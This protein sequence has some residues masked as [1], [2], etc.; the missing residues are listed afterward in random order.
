MEGRIKIHRKIEAWE[1]YTDANVFRV[2]FHL[3]IK[4]NHKDWKRQWIDVKRWQV[5]I[6]R[7]S[8][9]E[10]LWLT[11][12]QVRTALDKLE[13]TWEITSQSTNRFTIVTLVKYCD[14][15]DKDWENN[16]QSNKPITNEQQTD[17]KRITTNKNDKK[18]KNEKEK[19]SKEENA[20]AFIENPPV[21]WNQDIQKIIQIMKE[22]CD[23]AWLVYMPWYTER[24]FAKHISSKTLADKIAKYDMPLETFIKNIIKLSAQPYM[25][26]CNT[27]QLFYQNWWFVLNASKNNQNNWTKVIDLTEY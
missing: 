2:F 8:L 1:R 19:Y 25:K 12:Q 20:N 16:Q 21:Y 10:Q 18:E 23:E 15:N 14:Y 9:A 11:V 17:N 26:A 13:S 5:I 6:W 3:L 22:W 27:P 7:I 24:N 4:A